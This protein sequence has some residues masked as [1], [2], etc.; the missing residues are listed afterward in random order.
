VIEAA[1]KKGAEVVYFPEKAG[2]KA[3]SK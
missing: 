2:P 1:L 3:K